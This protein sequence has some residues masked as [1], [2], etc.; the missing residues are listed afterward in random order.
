MR[1][2]TWLVLLAA[3][4]ATA[5]GGAAAESSGKAP[6]SA[7]Q[8]FEPEPSTIDEAQRAIDRARAQLEPAPSEAAPATPSST[9]T[10][11]PTGGSAGAPTSSE[12]AGGGAC[13]DACRALGSMKRAVEALCRM[14][15][16]GEPRCVAAR[17]TLSDS[18]TRV[19][20]C[21]CSPAG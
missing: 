4:L 19:A 6:A 16:E 11:P 8:P 14:T 2:R 7:T 12:E 13:A 17:R 20:R 9:G 18:V 1:T 10:A 5:C 21:S 3:T 15:G